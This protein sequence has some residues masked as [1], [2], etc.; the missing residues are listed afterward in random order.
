MKHYTQAQDRPASTPQMCAMMDTAHIHVAKFLH[1]IQAWH[2][3]LCQSIARLLH[4]LTPVAADTKDAPP[5]KRRLATHS[6]A[7][8]I[9]IVQ[10]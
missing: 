6:A 8:V 4:G 2:N 10:K 9:L 7:V 3:I 1:Y 5:F